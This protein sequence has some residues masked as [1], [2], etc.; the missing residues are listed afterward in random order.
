MPSVYKVGY[1]S[2]IIHNKKICNL[3]TKVSPHPQITKVNFIWKVVLPWKFSLLNDTLIR[4][5]LWKAFIDGVLAPLGV[6]IYWSSL[7]CVT[8]IFFPSEM[9]I[10][11]K[12]ILKYFEFF[13]IFIKL[14][15]CA[16]WA[17]TEM[18]LCDTTLSMKIV[19]CSK[20]SIV[21]GL[22]KYLLY[23]WRFGFRI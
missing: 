2:T 4:A 22:L 9:I 1:L 23:S 14:Q 13:F 10:P 21:G 3:N 6:F 15:K 12:Q 5:Q 17:S 11:M 16:S 19:S 8:I 18:I 20:Y 7:S